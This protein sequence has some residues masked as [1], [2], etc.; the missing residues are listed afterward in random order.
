MRYGKKQTDDKKIKRRIVLV[1]VIFTFLYLIIAARVVHLQVFQRDFLAD[2]ASREYKKTYV[3][4]GK[5]GTIYDRNKTEMAVSIDTVSIG[6]HPRLIQETS[7]RKI[8]DKTAAIAEVLNADY[9]DILRKLSADKTFLWL[10]RD[11]TPAEEAAMKKLGFDRGV[12]EF[13]PERK[14]VY[15]NRTLAA[16]LFGFSGIDGNGLEGLEYACDNILKGPSVQRTMV[17]DAIGGGFSTDHQADPPAASDGNNIVLTIDSTIQCIT[18]TV[19][20]DTVR[21]FD[22]I[23]GMAVVMAPHTGEVLAMAN[24]PFFNPNTFGRY[25][26]SVWRN[27]V[28]TDSFEPGS[29]MKVFLAAGAIESGLCKPGTIFFCE[30]GAYRIHSHQIHDAHSYGWLSLRQ[31]VKYSSNIGAVKVSE[32]IGRQALWETLRGFGFGTKTGVRCPGETNGILSYYTRWTD[33]DTGSIAFG[34]GIS[35]SAIQLVTALSAIANGGVLLKPHVVKKVVAP[36]GGLVRK[37]DVERVRRVISV[38]TAR[39]IQSMMAGVTREGGT[40]ERAAIEEYTVCGKTGTAQKLGEQGEYTDDEFIASFMGFAPAADPE[41]AVLV[42]V[43][44]P[45]KSHYGGT[46][47]APA[48]R[49]IASETLN[50][51]G[52]DPNHN[53]RDS[54]RVSIDKEVGG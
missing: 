19:L 27:R 24:Y 38:N 22:A 34:Q 7:K 49:R 18:E 53:N 4:T 10:K 30:Q 2:K 8:S 5:R 15:P 52:V 25:N 43:D 47:T 26:E 54:L 1:G 45:Q 36:D 16:Q 12:L 42:V 17:R 28:V 37:I 50:Y 3:D 21:S 11:A 14:R 33:I 48:F 29:T 44:A 31:I 23:S 41:I 39:T 51:L 20:A 13:I 9:N 32:M 46:V 40:G 6:V 35:V